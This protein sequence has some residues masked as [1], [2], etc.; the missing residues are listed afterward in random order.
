MNSTTEWKSYSSHASLAMLGRPW[1]Y[2]PNRSSNGV[3][4][5][6]ACDISQTAHKT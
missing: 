6:E 3:K 2:I 4:L 5:V 1:G